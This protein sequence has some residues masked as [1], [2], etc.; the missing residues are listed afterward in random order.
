MDHYGG[1]STLTR[2]TQY[3]TPNTGQR[4]F[5]FVDILNGINDQIN[6]ITDAQNTTTD[7][8]VLINIFADDSTDVLGVGD[9]VG[10]TTAVGSVI[11]WDNNYTF[12]QGSWK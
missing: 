6:G 11:V 2:P 12:S 5:T 1:E 10:T 4:P 3:Y 7:S 9:T 8:G